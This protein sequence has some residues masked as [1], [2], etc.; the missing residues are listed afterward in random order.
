[1]LIAFVP[2]VFALIGLLMYVLS[3]NGKLAEV[4]RLMFAYAFLITMWSFASKVFRI[5]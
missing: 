2:I 3:A 5:G 4:G 1:M